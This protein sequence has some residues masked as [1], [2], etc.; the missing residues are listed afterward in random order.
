[1]ETASKAKKTAREIGK[2]NRLANLRPPWKPGQSGNGVGRRRGGASISE[3]INAFL[4]VHPDTGKPA[5]SMV[6]LKRIAERDRAPARRAAAV[7]VLTATACRLKYAIDRHGDAYLTGSDP[8]PGRALERI[9]DRL[10]GKP[11]QTVRIEREST[12]EQLTLAS[13][14]LQQLLTDPRL[15]A[16]VELAKRSQVVDT[17]ATALPVPI[18]PD[19]DTKP[20]ETA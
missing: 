7:E 17:E 11:R 6:K 16:L 15:P 14:R 4:E 10:E 18:R 3:W 5:Y 20:T 8:E 2:E 9:M 12:A 1:M 13:A 19:D